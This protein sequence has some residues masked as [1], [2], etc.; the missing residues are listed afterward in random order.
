[1]YTDINVS[2]QIKKICKKRGITISGLERELGW[3]NGVIGRWAKVSP[4]IDKIFTVAS[5]LE[6]SLDELLGTVRAAEDSN[7]EEKG[8]FEKI[9][10]ITE[11]KQL[12]WKQIAPEEKIQFEKAAVSFRCGSGQICKAYKADWGSGTILLTVFYEEDGGNI[13]N[14]EMHLYLLVEGGDAEEEN[15]RQDFLCRTLKYV[16]AVLFKKW[17]S[18]RVKEFKRELLGL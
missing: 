17:N 11:K 14:L 3:S 16:D 5:Q 1:M 15:G 6:V 4:S 8:I 12:I 9:Y 7:L 13:N 18:T 10:D 2:E